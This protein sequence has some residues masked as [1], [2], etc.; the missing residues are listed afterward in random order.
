[1]NSGLEL[2][3]A[4]EIVAAIEDWRDADD[5]S[6]S[7]GDNSQGTED[8]YYQTLT[9]PYRTSGR[10]FVALEEL[11]LLRGI[12]DDI[13]NDL[14]LPY[15]TIYGEGSINI[16]TA[17]IKVLDALFGIG[18][19]GLAAKI[20]EY[21]QGFDGKI[22][23]TDDRWF[24][25]GS[26]IIEGGKRGL[27]EVKDLNDQNW[28]GNIFGIDER[29]YARLRELIT[30]KALLC[31]ASDIYRATAS[32]SVGKIKKVVSTVV[33]FNAPGALES[34]GFADELP[35]PDVKYLFWHEA[36]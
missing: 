12:S 7:A 25:M 8:A 29:E 2:E 23:S 32:A 1:M 20:V 18:Y 16:N 9:V 10:E 14:L 13:Y 5:L 27:I 22:G 33:Q 17:H 4:D 3:K 26:P 36:R 34:S 31:T 11:L 35:A 19:P 28:Y 15:V 6:K 21:R 30:E 24:I